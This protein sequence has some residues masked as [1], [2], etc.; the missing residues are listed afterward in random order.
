MLFSHKTTNRFSFLKSL[1]LVCPE[2]G[3]RRKDNP[4]EHPSVLNKRDFLID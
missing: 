1:P 3:A 4:G 2:G